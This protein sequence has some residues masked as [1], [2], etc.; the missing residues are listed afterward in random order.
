MKIRRVVSGQ[1]HAI[2]CG[3]CEND[4]DCSESKFLGENCHLSNLTTR[5]EGVKQLKVSK[6]LWQYFH[7]YFAQSFWNGLFVFYAL[8]ICCQTV[9]EW[10]HKGRHV[11]GEILLF[12]RLGNKMMF[13]DDYDDNDN[14]CSYHGGGGGGG[15]DWPKWTLFM[16]SPKIIC[17][18]P[19]WVMISWNYMQ[20]YTD[21]EV[22]EVEKGSDS[23]PSNRSPS[24]RASTAGH[25]D[26][27]GDGDQK[28]LL[29]NLRTDWHG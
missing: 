22:C 14:D 2:Q 20:V 12:T 6:Q 21:A 17:Y 29:T 18:G 5:E 23:L 1:R 4:F 7:F 24:R 13:K 11:D 8:L 16:F 15:K 10:R 3:H 25:S 19:S 27:V 28:V 9:G 26:D